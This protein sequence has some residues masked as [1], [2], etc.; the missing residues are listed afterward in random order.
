MTRGRV[1]AAVL[2]AALVVALIAVTRD[3]SSGTSDNAP[4]QATPARPAGK[5][6]AAKAPAAKARPRRH[7]QGV[8]RGKGRI[9]DTPAPGTGAL[10]AIADQKPQT[11]T[12]PEFR[13]LGVA[14]SRLNT[15]W[16][17]IFTEPARLGE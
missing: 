5:S 10:L 11:F 12:D 9:P 17:S 13:R 16:N 1:I 7:R 14:R 6:P 2:V 3:G 4:T 15:P 8:R